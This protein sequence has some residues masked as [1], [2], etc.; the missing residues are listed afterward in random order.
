M[1]EIKSYKIQITQITD[2]VYSY[3]KPLGF[4]KKGQTFNRSIGSNVIQAINLQAGTSG[5]SGN[6][7]VN[8]G[9]WKNDNDSVKKFI[10]PRECRISSR[11]GIITKERD[12]WWKIEN[13]QTAD[14]I[15]K[16]IELALPW[17]DSWRL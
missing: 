11:I 12:Y 16:E 7:T 14:E 9:L 8:F 17:F 4:R 3:L 10:Q 13:P 6:I 1:F 2:S 5:L 15:I